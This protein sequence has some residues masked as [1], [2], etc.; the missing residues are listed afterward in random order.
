MNTDRTDEHIRRLF[1]D[2]R[3]RLDTYLF[4]TE[5][6][7]RLPSRRKGAWSRTVRLV[8]LATSA[9]VVIA[10]LG[11]GVSA[12][13]HRLGNN[14]GV[15]VINDDTLGAVPATGTTEASALSPSVY[16]SQAWRDTLLEGLWAGNVD[17]IPQHPNGLSADFWEEPTNPLEI[18]EKLVPGWSQAKP[19]WIMGNELSPQEAVSSF[20][21]QSETRPVLVLAPPRELLDFLGL[22]EDAD[23]APQVA[24]AGGLATILMRMP[25]TGWQIMWVRSA[26]SQPPTPEVSP[27]RAAYEALVRVTMIELQ[28]FSGGPLL[29]AETGQAQGSLN[30]NG[31][32]IYEGN[33]GDSLGQF[34]APP[35]NAKLPGAYSMAEGPGGS[36]FLLDPVAEKVQIL[37]R[38]GKP[39]MEV[40]LA[41]EAPEDIA[42]SPDA[43]FFV[44][45]RKGTG[46]VQAYSVSSGLI[47]SVA[48]SQD[49]LS[50]T[51]LVGAPIG[52][53]GA[54][55][56]VS[57]S[58]GMQYFCQLYRF[59]QGSPHIYLGQPGAGGEE[60]I[61][62]V[63]SFRL[64]PAFG[65]PFNRS[66]LT[67]LGQAF[68]G[69]VKMEKSG[70][71]LSVSGPRGP[72]DVPLGLDDSLSLEQVDVVTLVKSLD[73]DSRNCRVMVSGIVRTSDAETR[74]GVWL[75]D[76]HGQVLEH[77]LLSD[78]VGA[79]GYREVSVCAS[80]DGFLY[81]ME[82]GDGGVRVVRY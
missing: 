62:P 17:T 19:V 57:S 78:Q 9:V 60:D 48:A 43:T 34:A 25:D 77:F 80:Y 35:A 64:W 44:N 56:E 26:S 38:S 24:K 72:F 11:I 33:W 27:A 14:G 5:L 31:T 69:S 52:G 29:N 7:E 74:R 6:A 41:A 66:E 15:I 50:V 51:G 68:W 30:H 32:V 40:S 61:L 54:Y 70:P 13:A 49:G 10:A 47:G 42:V 73:G 8:A 2:N 58:K 23:G 4:K 20:R 45:D 3:A 76:T 21:A 65:K 1:R 46:Q 63:Q 12:L 75:F 22:K 55:A 53:Y 16:L 81:V 71:H 36:L 67:P 28:S 18:P 82:A 59:D 37:S 79:G 39:I